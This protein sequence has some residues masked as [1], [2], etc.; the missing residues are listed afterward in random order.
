[1][2]AGTFYLHF[3]TDHGMEL[4]YQQMA[5]NLASNGSM[6]TEST[7]NVYDQYSKTPSGKQNATCLNKLVIV[8]IQLTAMDYNLT[9]S[10][11][12]K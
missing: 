9:K 4:T 3:G 1:M 2:F 12:Q 5:S 8:R 6:K 10:R 11:A 7:P